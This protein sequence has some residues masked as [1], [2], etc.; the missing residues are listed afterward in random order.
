MTLF[1]SFDKQNFMNT[2]NIY[3]PEGLRKELLLLMKEKQISQ[4]DIAKETGIYNSQISFFLNGKRD[5]AAKA[6]LRL[7]DF[8]LKHQE[9]PHAT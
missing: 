2:S 7:V 6:I 1:L 4:S 9:E 8:Y 3:T 5:L